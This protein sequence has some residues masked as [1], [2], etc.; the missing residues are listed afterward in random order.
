MAFGCGTIALA[1]A[2]ALAFAGPSSTS[3][4]VPARISVEERFVLYQEL[5]PTLVYD[6][7][8]LDDPDS[9]QSQALEWIAMT[10][11]MYWDPTK[12]T[13]SEQLKLENRY[14]LAVFYFSMTL[15]EARWSI[16]R[17]PET[18]EDLACVHHAHE[19]IGVNGMFFLCQ[20]F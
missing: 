9:A 14:Y 18:G 17:M 1:I 11:T 16:C 8:S 15:G 12:L 5:I 19:S 10:D 6:P 7:A 3:N 13:E 20:K 2:L 4:V